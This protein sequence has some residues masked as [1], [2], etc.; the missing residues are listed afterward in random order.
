MNLIHLSH[1]TLELSLAYLKCAQN[2]YIRLQLGK[3]IEWKP[4]FNSVEYHL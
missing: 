3:I 1:W 4:Y 2:T